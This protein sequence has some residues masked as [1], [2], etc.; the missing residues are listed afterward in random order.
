MVKKLNHNASERDRRKK[1]NGLYSSLRSLLPVAKNEEVELSR[2][3]FLC[4]E[5]Y[6][7]IAGA[8]GEIGRA[9]VS[10]NRLSDSE[11]AIQIS[12]NK[13]EVEK[14]QL[15]EILHLLEQQGFLLLGATS[16]ES[17]GGMIFCNIHLQVEPETTY[18][19]TDS[20]IEALRKKVLE[21]IV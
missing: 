9:A 8:T 11:V 17:F 2:D 5:I 1:V 7:R 19:L 16:S 13:D 12:M 20:D 15:S 4:S 10:V 6:T 14:T 3:G 18:Q 21:L